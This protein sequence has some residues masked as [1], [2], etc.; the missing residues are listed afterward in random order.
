MGTQYRE[1]STILFEA[2]KLSCARANE[3]AGK[4][5]RF[6][7][8]LEDR[9]FA[10]GRLPDGKACFQGLRLKKAPKGQA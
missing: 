1:G 8:R 9:G 4:Q 2:W 7:M 5:K 3:E 10:K 6:S